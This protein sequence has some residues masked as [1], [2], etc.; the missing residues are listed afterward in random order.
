MRNIVVEE[1]SHYKSVV[2]SMR[3][4]SENIVVEE[5]NHHG[6]VVHSAFVA[7][8]YAPHCAGARLSQ[9]VVGPE[10]SDKKWPSVYGEIASSARVRKRIRVL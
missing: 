8:I 9:T 10:I 2:H 3:T 4:M 7:A 6:S 5:K 1:K